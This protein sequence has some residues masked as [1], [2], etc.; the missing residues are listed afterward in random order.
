MSALFIYSIR[1]KKFEETDIKHA[2][3]L[4][5]GA[6]G[7]TIAAIPMVFGINRTGKY[8]YVMHQLSNIPIKWQKCRK[9]KSAIFLPHIY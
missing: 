3:I 7:G 2:L 6:L 1:K 5:L 8:Y 9:S 4:L